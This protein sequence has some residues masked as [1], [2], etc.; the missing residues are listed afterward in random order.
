MVIAR[1]TQV[2]ELV[3]NPRTT[4]RLHLAA[5]TT[6]PART[7]HP[8]GLD[9]QWQLGRLVAPVVVV[10]ASHYQWHLLVVR[11]ASP[12]PLV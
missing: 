3:N 12:R 9:R 11:E 7:V 5:P 8:L 10:I 1:L 6:P 4:A 2:P